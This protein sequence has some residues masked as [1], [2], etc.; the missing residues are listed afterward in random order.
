M[1]FRRLVLLALLLCCMAHGADRPGD[2]PH[3]NFYKMKVGEG[4]VSL[5]VPPNTTDQQLEVLL[6][7]IRDRVQQ[8]KFAELVACRS[9]FVTAYAAGGV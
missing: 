4:L 8:G 2:L 6:R 1:H 5:V 9:E 3:F 7:F